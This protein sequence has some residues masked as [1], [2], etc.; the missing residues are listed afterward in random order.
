MAHSDPSATGLGHYGTYINTRA[1]PHETN[2]PNHKYD[3]RAC[4]ECN[5]SQSKRSKDRTGTARSKLGLFARQGYARVE[6]DTIDANPS[7]GNVI[8]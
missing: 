5:Y 1:R 4:R 6:H 2:R 8:K 3:T 7:H